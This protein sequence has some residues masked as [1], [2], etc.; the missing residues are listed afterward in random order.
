[1][2]LICASFCELAIIEISIESILAHEFLVVALLDNISVFH[3]E[4][5]IRI[6]DSGQ[7][8]GNNKGGPAFHEFVHG[9]LNQLFCTGID[10]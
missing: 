5:Q 7:A 8:M 10:R 3:H 1:M 6:T 2:L 9:F 4:N